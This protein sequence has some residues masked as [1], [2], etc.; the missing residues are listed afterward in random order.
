[1]RDEMKMMVKMMKCVE[2]DTAKAIKRPGRVPQYSKSVK[3]MA[4]YTIERGRCC[5]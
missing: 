3:M 4:A 2:T 1:M 5:G